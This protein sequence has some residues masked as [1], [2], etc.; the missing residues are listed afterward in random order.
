MSIFN[1]AKNSKQQG[2][3]GLAKAIAWFTSKCYVVS[4]PLTDSQDYDLVAEIDGVLQKIQVRTTNAVEKSGAFAVDLRV[5][6]G[7]RSGTGRSKSSSQITYDILFVVTGA[8][9]QYLIPKKEIAYLERGLTLNASKD[10]Y[11]VD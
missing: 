6:G 7:N 8:G 9:T 2:D 11:K 3:I 10:C 1:L 5:Q 4:I